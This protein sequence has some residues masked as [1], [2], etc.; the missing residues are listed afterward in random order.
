MGTEKK[1]GKRLKDRGVLVALVGVKGQGRQNLMQRASSTESK[2]GEDR[3][4][5]WEEAE[6]PIDEKRPDWGGGIR[7]RKRKSAVKIDLEK[8]IWT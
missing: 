5:C 3:G 1:E 7:G 6:V 4:L 2:S 8:K